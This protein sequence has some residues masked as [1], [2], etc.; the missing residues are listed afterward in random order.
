RQP[1]ALCGVVGM[2]P[3]YGRVSRNGLVAFASGLDQ[4]GI[5]TRTVRECAEILGVIAGRDPLDSTSS[6]A[7]V[8]DYTADVD[9]GVRGRRFGV[10]IEAVE[11]LEGEVRANF[12]AAL[13][14]LRA[15]GAV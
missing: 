12:D 14:V 10:V 15:G 4:I 2:K 11:K 9:A 13:D 1:A 3:T 6:D 5:V 7:A 8:D